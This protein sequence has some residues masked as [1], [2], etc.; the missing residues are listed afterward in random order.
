MMTQGIEEMMQFLRCQ[1]GFVSRSQGLSLGWIVFAVLALMLIMGPGQ[2]ADASHVVVGDVCPDLDNY[3]T[4]WACDWLEKCRDWSEKI[5]II[6][7]TYIIAEEVKIMK[8]PVT[9]CLVTDK[10]CPW[11]HCIDTVMIEIVKPW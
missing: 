11:F 5:G 3:E 4:K 7:F 9:G 10:Q 1:S 6:K 8:L 2:P